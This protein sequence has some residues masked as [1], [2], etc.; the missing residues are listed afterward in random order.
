M[1]KTDAECRMCKLY[2]KCDK[3]VVLWREQGASDRHK[4]SAGIVEGATF[5]KNVRTIFWR[6]ENRE[7]VKYPKRQAGI[8]K[9]AKFREKM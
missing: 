8:V 6:R 2:K 4:K 7:H 3:N 1:Y 5:R 9:G